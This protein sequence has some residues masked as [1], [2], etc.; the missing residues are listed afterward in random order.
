MVID[1]FTIVNFIRR[2]V[3]RQI[4]IPAVLL[5]IVFFD[6]FNVSYCGNPVFSAVDSLSNNQVNDSSLSN[7]KV[8]NLL[9]NIYWKAGKDTNHNF[10]VRV[11]SSDTILAEGIQLPL[12]NTDNISKFKMKLQKE[13]PGFLLP[14][15]HLEL[16]RSRS[17]GSLLAFSV[18]VITESTNG[19]LT[20]FIPKTPTFILF[21]DSTINVAPTKTF[22][23]T[24][25]N[26]KINKIA[27]Q[28]SLTITAALFNNINSLPD[29][30]PQG[31]SQYYI[32]A[33]IPLRKLS[34]IPD[35][36][37]RFCD[38]I[39]WFRN[40]Y[41]TPALNASS[42]NYV[43]VDSVKGDF[44]ANRLDLLQY[45]YFKLPVNLNI[46]TYIYHQDSLDYYHIYLYLLEEMIFT[47]DTNRS[48][49]S[50]SIIPSNIWGFGISM[51]SESSVSRDFTLEASA[52]IFQINPITN[53]LNADLNAQYR[54][55][56]D[57]AHSSNIH[58]QLLGNDKTF[59]ALE[60]LIIYH[61]NSIA[62][63]YLHFNYVSKFPSSV[64]YTNNYFQIQLGLS[65]DVLSFLRNFSGS[66]GKS[67]SSSKSTATTN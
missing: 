17:E 1:C 50:S 16:T 38:N 2:K 30:D 25:T 32:L 47:K 55:L 41:F 9:L 18:E 37:H 13:L 36:S 56:G 5:F 28:D 62:S 64:Y 7:S 57:T 52:S 43:A 4:T 42:L 15:L 14:N 21:G 33:S 46:A 8:K 45:A 23:S 29:N 31:F 48:L 10:L 12:S 27:K 58:K 44:H 35:T 39:I 60:A 61:I 26:K 6:P 63:T 11:F 65:V 59:F 54:N 34:G 19:T 53:S 49:S 3:K 22:T 20:I 66:G 24:K 67:S 40:L 51:K